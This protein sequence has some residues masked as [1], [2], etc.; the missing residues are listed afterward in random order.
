MKKI[1]IDLFQSQM[2]KIGAHFSTRQ[3][4]HILVTFKGLNLKTH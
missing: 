1:Q 2:K 3:P 4:V